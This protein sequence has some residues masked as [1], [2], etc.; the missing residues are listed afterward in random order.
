MNQSHVNKSHVKE[1]PNSAVATTKNQ[2]L[3]TIPVAFEVAATLDPSHPRYRMP[4]HLA[5]LEDTCLNGSIPCEGDKKGY[6]YILS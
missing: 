5:S 4:S 2:V 6:T 1:F 3:V